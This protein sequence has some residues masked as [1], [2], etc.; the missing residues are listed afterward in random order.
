MVPSI[1]TFGTK[2]LSQDAFFCWLLSWSEQKYL[3][4]EVHQVA[5][6]ILQEIIG[7]EIIVKKLCITQ[8]YKN[9]DFYLRINENLTVCFEDKISTTIHDDQLERYSVSISEKYPNDRLFFVYLKTDIVFPE[10]KEAVEK[11]GYIILDLFKINALLKNKIK[12]DIYNDFV[13][14]IDDKVKSY[15][16]FEK[17]RCSKWQKNEWVGFCNKLKN[18]FFEDADMGF[19]QGREFYFIMHESDYIH[20]KTVYT[21]LEIKHSQGNNFGRLT[22]LLHIDDGRLNKYNIRDKIM[23]KINNVFKNVNKQVNNRVGS[24]INLV[25]FND[26]PCVEKGFINYEKS[27]EYVINIYNKFTKIKY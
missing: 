25:T 10:E 1:F 14:Y 19:W 3:N 11:H 7:E 17:I 2:E 8:Q 5:K 4:T 20:D 13:S 18:D 6:S 22:I 24:L 12:N 9:I 26:F 27:R 16:D 15:T 23:E 21:S